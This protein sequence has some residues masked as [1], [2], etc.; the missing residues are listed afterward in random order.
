[1]A[2]GVGADRGYVDRYGAQ[3]AGNTGIR[4]RIVNLGVSGQTSSELLA[5]VRNDRRVRRALGGAEV[6]TLNIGLND[7]GR[8]GQA[9]QSGGCG[10]E[11]GERCLRA[12]V[13]EVGKNWGAIV[14]EIQSLLR[15]DDAIVRTPGLGYVPRA[16]TDAQPYLD[17][18]NRR[19]AATAD[20]NGIPYVEVRLGESGMSPDGIH[21]NE[22]GYA[23]IAEKLAESGYGSLGA[24][25]P[26]R[27]RS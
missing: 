17:E 13:D 10:G 27:G 12:A 19:I 23:T 14:A 16:G 3:L 8:A 9:Y 1:L 22:D 4:I 11:D 18:V 25:P 24:E 2:A 20:R 7:L 26:G 21:P 15:R 6:V 5:A